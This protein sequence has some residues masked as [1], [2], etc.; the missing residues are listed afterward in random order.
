MAIAF[1]AAV[2]PAYAN[3]TTHTVGLTV[4]SGS[5]RLLFVQLW[6][7][8]T[9]GVPTSVA[10]AGVSMTQVLTT[11]N[12]AGVEK[13][14]LWYLFAPASGANN[15]VVSFSGTTEAMVSGVSYSGCAQ[16]GMPDAST[17]G[18]G[19]ST[20][21]TGTVTTIADNCWAH[22][23]LRTTGNGNSDA[24]GGTVRRT[25]GAGFTQSYDGNGAKTPAG[26]Y[27]LNAT[28]TSQ[29]RA[30]LMVSFA[31]AVPS[32]FTPRASFIM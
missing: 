21:T 32:T 30:Y 28:H 6:Y 9:N 10:Y 14:S 31:P 12:P 4:G 25:N 26:S 27:S 7:N 2:N 5:D 18:T 22:M 16:S 3:L 15:I 29:P 13:V 1:D 24:G 23:L 8:D 17:S 20:N 11:L 19:T